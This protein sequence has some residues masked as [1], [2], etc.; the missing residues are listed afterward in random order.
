MSIL[1]SDVATAVEMEREIQCFKNGNPT[2]ARTLDKKFANH[3]GLD[4]VE[5][6]DSNGQKYAWITSS[7]FEATSPVSPE[8]PPTVEITMHVT[9]V[10]GHPQSQ[11]IHMNNCQVMAGAR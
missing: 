9:I 4:R 6:L 11:K 8:T 2:G 1:V 7:S 3:F 10:L 5:F